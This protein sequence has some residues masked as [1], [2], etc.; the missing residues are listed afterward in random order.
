MN[1]YD[2]ITKTIKKIDSENER[3]KPLDQ[4][5]FFKTYDEGYYEGVDDTLMALRE[6]LR[7]FKA[8]GGKS[9]E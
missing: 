1:L 7:Q 3:R 6:T 8:N 4:D 9:N 5:D 2:H